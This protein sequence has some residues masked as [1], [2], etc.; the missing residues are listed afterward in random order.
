MERT[1]DRSWKLEPNGEAYNLVGSLGGQMLL[2]R[3]G[4]MDAEDFANKAHV[5]AAAPEL[6]LA[7]DRIFEAFKDEPLEGEQ[8]A[9]MFDLVNALKKAT[10]YKGEG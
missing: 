8:L 10:A 5:A 4:P 7:G 2:A 9:A 3:F 6:M 1:I